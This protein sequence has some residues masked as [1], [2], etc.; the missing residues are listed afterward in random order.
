MSEKVQVWRDVTMELGK[1][2][3]RKDQQ[4]P[5]TY[6]DWS[7]DAEVRFGH[8]LSGYDY[9][10]F[11]LDCEAIEHLAGKDLLYQHFIVEIKGFFG[12]GTF[13]TKKLRA[14]QREI[15]CYFGDYEQCHRDNPVSNFKPNVIEKYSA[16][17]L[18]Q[19]IDDEVRVA[20][21]LKGSDPIDRVYN[22]ENFALRRHADLGNLLGVRLRKNAEALKANGTP[23]KLLQANHWIWFTWDLGKRGNS[24]KSHVSAI[25]ESDSAD[26][27]L[28]FVPPLYSGSE[29]GIM[30]VHT[31]E[32]LMTA[33]Y[34]WK[35]LNIST[36]PRD[37]M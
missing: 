17:D 15:V 21:G 33:G 35:E 19:H 36:M 28:I 1:Y 24:Y 37:D 4:A 30:Y 20:N 9:N 13:E 10:S 8:L 11:K 14:G 3:Q 32:N 2:S 27:D 12:S 25:A 26:G 23:Y 18:L 5:V 31:G 6:C 7:K 16:K 22:T 34:D 29:Y